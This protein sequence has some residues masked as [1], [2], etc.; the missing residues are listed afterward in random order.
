MRF[1]LSI[2]MIFGFLSC[3][4]NQGEVTILDPY[5]QEPTKDI[6]FYDI[7]TFVEELVDKV[8][9]NRAIDEQ[10]PKIFF[11]EIKLHESVHEI[12]YSELIIDE[13]KEKMGNLLDVSY[14]NN[15]SVDYTLHGKLAIIPKKKSNLSKKEKTYWFNL[16]F[17]DKKTETEKRY[18]VRI[19]K[20]F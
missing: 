13:L 2:L 17:R 19:R 12:S 14:V 20:A 3:S 7:D 5:D 16:I 4:K 6:G 9:A 8:S 11:G 10:K 1:F 15:P 18:S